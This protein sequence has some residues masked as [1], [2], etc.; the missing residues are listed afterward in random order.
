[1]IFSPFF[2]LSNYTSKKYRHRLWKS[3]AEQKT[4]WTKIE[5]V[6]ETARILE[7]K[8]NPKKTGKPLVWSPEAKRTVVIM[9]FLGTCMYEIRICLCRIDSWCCGEGTIDYT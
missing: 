4:E 6:K 8:I 3:K 9:P 5:P 7:E 1:M 2:S